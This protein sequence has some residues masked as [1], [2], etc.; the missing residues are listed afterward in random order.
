MVHQSRNRRLKERNQEQNQIKE[1]LDYC[2]SSIRLSASSIGLY[3]QEELFLSY[4]SGI[5]LLQFHNNNL[6]I[7]SSLEIFNKLEE[8]SN[9]FPQSKD[10]WVFLNAVFQ[11]LNEEMILE[12][13]LSKEIPELRESLIDDTLGT[14]LQNSLGTEDR[15]RLAANYTTMNSA[16]FLIKV[17][18][19]YTCSSII[20]PFCGTGRLISA[21]LK[22]IKG[23]SQF[24]YIRIHDLMPSAV[25]IAYC[26]LILIL[27]EHNQDFS[28]LHATIGDA[29][30]VFFSKESSNES[31]NY[32]LVLMNPPFTRTHRIGK[33]QK[34]NLLKIEQKYSKYLS[35]QIGLHVYAILLADLLM[36]ENGLLG[37]VLPAATILSQYSRGI[38]E[39]FLNNYQLNTIISSD[40]EKAYSEDST[41]REIIIIAKKNRRKRKDKIQFLRIN[42]HE[43]SRGKISSSILISEKVLAKEW[44]WTVFLRDPELLKIR[45]L[46]LQSRFIRSGNSLGLDIVRGV[47]MYGPEFFFIPNR[48]WEISYETSNEI[49]LK[50][51]RVTIEI[52]KKLLER[53][54]R[55][56]GKYKKFISPKVSDFALSI[57]CSEIISQTWIK[58]YLDFSEKYASPAKRKFGQY[59]ISHIYNQIKTK[60]PF[61]HLFLIDKFG[62]SS[63][64]IMAHFFRKKIICSKNF[65]VLKN[66]PATQAKLQAAWLNSSFFIILFLST[67]REIGGSYGRLQIVDYMNESLFLDI[68]RCETSIKSQIIKNFDAMRK[69]ELLPIPEQFQ[70]PQRR[71]LDHSIISS[72]QLQKKTGES[73]LNDMYETLKRVFINLERRDKIQRVKR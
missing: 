27:S 56:P 34:N 30:D 20:D 31:N 67:R 8:L 10:L 21:Y 65:Y 6:R 54:L 26:H 24:P 53:S 4:L 69:C 55:K 7:N 73:L 61:G 58:N 45:N 23:R 2:K 70:S 50:N 36:R 25:L 22:N 63:T 41:L 5:W 19:T 57:P 52:P 72:L 39:F 18:D 32:D 71:A 33:K 43:K 66:Y 49:I 35:G 9:R 28:L 3:N 16:N 29:F 46:L 37:A 60:K 51:D 13:L 40:D 64:G 44:N 48:E 62:V 42:S 17:L 12:S 68:M 15:K 38:H 59:W 47:E 1:W 11:F 14:I